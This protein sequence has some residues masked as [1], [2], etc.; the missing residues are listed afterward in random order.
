MGIGHHR[1][2][3]AVRMARVAKVFFTRRLAPA[4]TR[5]VAGER[6]SVTVEFVIMKPLIFWAFMALFVFFDGYRQ[7]SINLKA[8]YTI[9]D[10]LSRETDVVDD[11]YIDTMQSLFKFLT[12]DGSEASLRV[13]V[14]RWD[15][16]DER[17]YVDWSQVRDWS[18]E[19]AW[20]DG[21]I[22]QIESRLPVMAHMQR[23][24]LVET[25]NTYSPIF[26]VGLGEQEL[27]NFVFSSPRFAPQVVWGS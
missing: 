4:W 24:I 11:E 25:R 6:G 13:S 1:E 14:V 7:S 27:K 12:R 5:F 20:T 18:G 2:S 15:N 9:S 17:Y 23:A 8:A 26:K 21:S 3:G 22:S 19:T 10:I 16:N